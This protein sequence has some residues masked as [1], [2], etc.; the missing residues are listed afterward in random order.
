[1]MPEPAMKPRES[2]PGSSSGPVPCAVPRVST[3]ADSLPE[4]A[5]STPAVPEK[6]EQ[7]GVPRLGVELDAGLRRR[8]RAHLQQTPCPTCA[9]APAAPLVVA[10]TQDASAQT[11]SA[12][13][14]L[15]GCV[16]AGDKELREGSAVAMLAMCS[17]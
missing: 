6:V 17:E 7:G 2:I 16:C 11:A 5:S 8:A 12:R 9:S 14:H 15:L 4:D 13:G 10:A 3:G 1:M